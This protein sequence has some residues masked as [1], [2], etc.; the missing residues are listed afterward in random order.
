M[1]HE[2]RICSQKEEIPAVVVHFDVTGRLNEPHEKRLQAL[3]VFSE[4]RTWDV[5]L[6]PQ[7]S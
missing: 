5:H 3:V 7:T 4:P 1:K 2:E 6:S